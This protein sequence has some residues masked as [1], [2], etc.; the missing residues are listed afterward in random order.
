MPSSRESEIRACQTRLTGYNRDLQEA[1]DDLNDAIATEN[2][3]LRQS[4]IAVETHDASFDWNKAKAETK[5]ASEKY[6]RAKAAQLSAAAN[7]RVEEGKLREL[8]N[9]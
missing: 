1:S 3:V 7:V 2:E 9:C 4:T 6:H 8:Y 5:A